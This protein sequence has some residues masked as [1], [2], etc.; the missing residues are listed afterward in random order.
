ME[1]EL[2]MDIKKLSPKEQEELR[3]KIV[4]QMKKES[5]PIS[6]GKNLSLKQQP[7]LVSYPTSSL[8]ESNR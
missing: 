8:V 5:S 1:N 3:K 6:V 7:Y 2:V 4:R